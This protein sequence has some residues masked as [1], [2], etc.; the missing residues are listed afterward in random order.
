MADN[1]TVTNERVDDIPVLLAQQARMGVA[2]LLDQHFPTHGN[3]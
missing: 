2:E 1:L 3:R